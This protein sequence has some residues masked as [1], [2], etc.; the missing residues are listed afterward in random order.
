MNSDI[1][2][3]TD[4]VRSWYGI[5]IWHFTLLQPCRRQFHGESSFARSFLFFFQLFIRCVAFAFSLLY[6]MGRTK[7]PQPKRQVQF[8]EEARQGEVAPEERTMLIPIGP[9][10]TMKISIP[11]PKPRKRK[12]RVVIEEEEE[13]NVELVEESDEVIIEKFVNSVTSIRIQTK[14]RKDTVEPWRLLQQQEIADVKVQLAKDSGEESDEKSYSFA[15]AQGATA[16]LGHVFGDDNEDD[17]S[18]VGLAVEDGTVVVELD[19]NGTPTLSILLTTKALQVASPAELFMETAKRRRGNKFRPVKHLQQALAALFPDTIVAHVVQKKS[20]PA[21]TAKMVYDRVDNVQLE[22]Y[23]E[24][25]GYDQKKVLIKGLVPTLRPYQEAAVQWMLQRERGDGYHDEWKLAWVVLKE[26][27]TVVPLSGDHTKNG[28][29]Y[30]PFASWLVSSYDQAR[31]ATRGPAAIRGGILADSMGLGKT[32]EVVAC[33][34]ANP[35]VDDR[36]LPPVATRVEEEEKMEDDGPVLVSAPSTPVKAPKHQNDDNIMKVNQYGACMCGKDRSFKGCLSFV[37]CKSCREPM[38]GVCAGFETVEQLVAETTV[39]YP[40]GSF[41]KKELVRLCPDDWCPTCVFAKRPEGLLKSRATLIVTPPAILDQWEREIRRHTSV[42]NKEERVLPALASLMGIPNRSAKQSLKVVVYPGI[43]NL[44]RGMPGTPGD[45]SERPECHMVHPRV[46]ADADVVLTTFDALMGDLGHSDE[47]PY[48]D[49]GSVRLRG[50]KRYRVVPSPLTGIKWWRVC[51]DE[52]QKVEVPTA[53]S[54]RMA[55]KLET[56]HRWC[57]SGTPIGRGKL[58]DLYGLLLFLRLQPFSYKSWFQNCLQAGQKDTMQRVQRL[59]QHVLWRSTK[60]SD[61]VRIQMG[62]PAQVEKK[63]ILRFSSIEKH[64]YGRQLEQTMLAASD[65]IDKTGA[66]K[67]KSTKIDLLSQHLLRLRAACCHPQVGSTGLG[68]ATKKRKTNSVN[69]DGHTS[70]SA[71]SGVLTMDQILDRLIDDTKLQCEE[72]QRL[73]VMHTNAMAALSRLEVEAKQQG[74]VF[75]ESDEALLKK[76]CALYRES[77]DLTEQNSTPSSVIGEAVLTGCQGFLTPRKVVRDGRSAVQW[78]LS[79]DSDEMVLRELWARYDFEGP[80]KKICELKIQSLGVVPT[81]FKETGSRILY[82]KDCAFQVAHSSL[83]GEF[84]DVVSFSLEKGSTSDLKTLGGFRTNKSKAWRLVVKNFHDHEPCPAGEVVQFFVGLKV[85]LFEPDISS[86]SIQRLHVLHNAAMS[87][88]SLQQLQSCNDTVANTPEALMKRDIDGMLKECKK[89]ESLYLDGARA[90]H[91]EIKK[92]L[93]K[94]RSGR[95][96]AGTALAS[97]CAKG[98]GRKISD[99]W[100]DMWWDDVMSNCFLN[101]TPNDRDQL[102][103]R[104][105]NDL[106]SFSQSQI[107]QEYKTKHKGKTL[108]RFQDVDGLQTALSFRV[109]D[110][111]S[112]L[113]EEA[114]SKC[115]HK[116]ARLSAFPSETEQLQNSH[117]HKCHV[118]WNQTGPECNHCKLETELLKNEPD[119]LILCILSSIWKWLKDSKPSGKMGSARA[120]ARVD[121]RAEKFFDIIKASE[122]EWQRAKKAWRIHLDLLNDIDEVNQC[123]RSMRLARDDEDL[124][125]LT[126]DELN[127]I[128]VSVDIPIR[129]MDHGAKQAMSLGTLRRHTHTLRYLKNQNQERQDELKQREC[130][131]G[132]AHEMSNCILCLSE[133]E[134]E[135][136]VLGCGHSFHQECIQPLIVRKSDLAIITCPLRCTVKTKKHDIM[137]ASDRRK[138]DG[139]QRTRD[140]KGSWGTKVTR[141]VCDLVDVSDVGEKSIVFSQWEDMLWVVE[142]ALIANNVGYVR[143]KSLKKIGDDIKRF[144]S[145]D[146]PVLLLNVKNGAEGLTLVEAT[147]IFMVEPLLNCGL[148]SQAISRIHRIGQTRTT[149]VHRFLIEDTIEVKIDKLRVERQ[150]DQLEDSINEARQKHDIEGGGIDGGF[151]REELQDLLK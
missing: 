80:S 106:G 130:N 15:T 28:I 104:V 89:I 118:D 1:D 24:S 11:S 18:V 85:E 14:Q 22:K 67:R 112:E 62:I 23:E 43:R 21:V 74:A 73:A 102:C 113:G 56:E 86:D 131:D 8:D 20:V 116:F 30:C 31:D 134:G 95:K 35:F 149:Y 128:V 61:S 7:D 60:S 99:M 110:V 119:S 96:D 58:E 55:L 87:M 59:L 70:V 115:M 145:N 42:E 40:D 140:I 144:R 68:R 151:S 81:E 52:A 117:C 10:R 66:K 105:Q 65:V 29:F 46:L 90:I 49:D 147:H 150:E 94:A 13:V 143:V 103:L 122:K 39:E 84:V 123:K 138:D 127:A 53:T 135:R 137:I 129:L 9:N 76:S 41:D 57:V 64:F 91:A 124:T 72:S 6:N 12:R 79:A 38:H 82:P 71:G 26:N 37:L 2:I 114:H 108:P 100:H 139:S 111:I 19:F 69:A 32:V 98:S 27:G 75:E 132:K 133:M 120:T 51:L 101:G 33:M 107:G 36:K 44:F 5:G 126:N 88:T 148:D 109:T 17:M 48:I 3:N 146:C 4:L 47:N 45:S 141:L 50:R 77:L 136:A 142:Q 121:E 54:A 63:V 83:G 92:E 97:A 125:Q 93:G 25:G 16:L 34:L 78:K